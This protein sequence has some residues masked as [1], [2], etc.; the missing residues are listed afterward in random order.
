M[1]YKRVGNLVRKTE[2]GNKTT[3]WNI[4]VAVSKAG[5]HQGTN[6]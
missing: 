5:T 1:L 2:V 6:H 4:Y 3:D